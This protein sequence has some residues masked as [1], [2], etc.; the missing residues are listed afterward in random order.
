MIIVKPSVELV[1]PLEYETLLNTVELAIRNCYKSEDKIKEGSAEGIIR[2]C[3]K[4]EHCSPI[5]F[6]DICVKITTDRA[7]T[8]Q[9][10]RHRLC[11]FTQTSQRY[12]NYTSDKFGHEIQVVVPSG[13]NDSA[14]DTWRASMLMAESAYFKMVEEDNVPPEVARSVLPNSTATT[15]FVKANIREWRTIMNLRCDDH[16]Q[17][18]IRMLMKGLLIKLY[19]KYPVFFEDLYQKYIDEDVYRQEQEQY[20]NI[21]INNGD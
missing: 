19:R 8:H 16:A 20:N 2:G 6:G 15:I 21:P 1:N 7:V 17:K 13:L 9:L 11:S 10:V 5:E 18:D 12:V 14:Y 3:I 4:R